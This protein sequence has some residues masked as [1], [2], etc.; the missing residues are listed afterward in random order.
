MGS[1][2]T[3][4]YTSELILCSIPFVFIVLRGTTFIN[5]VSCL[6]GKRSVIP[7]ATG[8]GERILNWAGGGGLEAIPKGA[9][10]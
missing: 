6:F 7:L 1:I 8:M 2:S 10:L 4:I 5:S 9:N 3:L